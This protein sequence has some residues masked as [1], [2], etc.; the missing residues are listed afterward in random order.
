MTWVTG[1]LVFVIIWWLVFFTILPW[2]IRRAGAE[3]EG[4]DAGAPANPALLRKAL[5]TTVI[6]GVLFVGAWWVIEAGYFDHLI[7]Q[8]R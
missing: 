6:S 8:K 2:G 5:V 7:R 1:I 3:E 4:H